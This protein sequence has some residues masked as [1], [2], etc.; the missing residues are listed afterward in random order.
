MTPFTGAIQG[1]AYLPLWLM[2]LLVAPAIGSF[3]GVVVRRGGNMRS[4]LFGR[5]QCETCGHVLGWRDL[6]P[7]LSWLMLGRRCRYCHVKL[8]SFYPLIELTA[9]IPVL[10]AASV[11]TS[12]QLLAGVVF[13][14]MLLA[15]GLIDWRTQRLPNALTLSV[16]V[17]GIAAAFALDRPHVG[18]H[19]IGTIAG[20]AVFVLI[21]MFY[22]AVRKRDGLGMGDAKL[23]AGLGAWVSWQGLPVLV[24]LAAGMGLIFV[25]ARALW[26]RRFV[27]TERVPFGPFLAL[28]GWIVWLYGPSVPI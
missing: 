18:A 1:F 14:W 28:A 5:S 9:I 15:L 11:T 10:W 19:L 3:L 26:Q 12:W 20:F 7:I 25:L 6:V 23:L 27:M 2:L 22:R 13:G 21:A 16:A 8:S 24:L 4:I 17:T